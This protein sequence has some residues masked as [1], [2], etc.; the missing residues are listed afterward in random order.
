MPHGPSYR[1]SP[2]LYRG[3]CGKL[4]ERGTWRRCC[5]RPDCSPAMATLSDEHLRRSDQLGGSLRVGF[6]P[7]ALDALR[8]LAVAGGL[9]LRY[10]RRLLELSDSAQHLS[11]LR[12]NASSRCRPPS[13]GCK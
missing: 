12:I 4:G 1:A 8:G 9:E 5:R 3:V 10:E 6:A 13:R 7:T 2:R 11:D